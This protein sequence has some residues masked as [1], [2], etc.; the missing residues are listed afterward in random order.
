MIV[1]C[2]C[3]LRQVAALSAL[4][5]SFLLSAPVASQTVAG[6]PA[7][8]V[9]E[10]AAPEPALGASDSVPSSVPKPAR[11]R[12]KTAFL[13][14]VQHLA[15]DDYEAAAVAFE[16]SIAEQ[17]SLAARFNLANVYVA[18][19]RCTAGEQQAELL[20]EMLTE[21][22]EPDWREQAAVLDRARNEC[23]GTLELKVVPKTA[24]VTLDGRKVDASRGLR[25][26]PG[27]H[28]LVVSASGKRREE[29][30]LQVGRGTTQ[31]LSIELSPAQVNLQ[32]PAQAPH[33]DPGAVPSEA[34]LVAETTP[35][36]QRGWARP[37]ST[38]VAIVGAVST[39]VLYKVT[40]DRHA[41]YERRTAIFNQ[42]RF[43]ADADHDDL[44]AEQHSLNDLADDVGRLKVTL[45]TSAVVTTAAVAV[46]AWL[47]LPPRATPDSA[48]VS[49]FGGR[50]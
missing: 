8:G 33:G 39:V 20:A 18:L 26:D 15:S 13:E 9:Q 43:D 24:S 50:F 47:W 27:A 42:R 25:L 32:L 45:L 23:F 49:V 12:A 29:R 3:F 46:A 2:R 41:E 37:L 40:S 34:L 36:P 16:Q 5:S 4:S 10:G 22:S 19:G 31:R 48:G 1:R 17:P 28:R 11:E 38:S 35:G 14:G 6:S 44:V 21:R 30:N 7:P